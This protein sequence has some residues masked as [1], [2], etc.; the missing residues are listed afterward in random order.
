M[1]HQT[2]TGSHYAIGRRHGAALRAQGIQ[3]LKQVPFPLTRERLEFARACFPLYEQWFPGALEELRGLAEGQDC[4]REMLAAALLP[5]Y[6]LLPQSRCSCFAVRRNGRVFFGRN[7]DFLTAL[8][9]WNTNWLYAFTDGGF[10]FLGNTTAFVEMEDGVNVQGLAVGLTSVFPTSPQPGL[11]AGML[12]R[13]V[14][15]TCATVDQALDLLCRVPAASS[16]TLVLA[17]RTGDIALVESCGHR[18]AYQRPETAEGYVC[19]VNMFH[20]LP[21][22]LPQSPWDNW[23]SARRYETMTRALQA[24][25]DSVESAMELLSGKRGFLCQYDS[26]SGADTVWAVACDLTAGR[27]YRAEDNPGRTPFT[28]DTRLRF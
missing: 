9:D 10:S 11:Q 14:L 7:S 13:L 26:S 1:K 28:E 4:D 12:L 20:L 17:D 25:V 24:G 5:M 16:H 22:E 18:M 23:D 15:E 27:I 19:A 6:C 3:L 2:E 21:D 8:K